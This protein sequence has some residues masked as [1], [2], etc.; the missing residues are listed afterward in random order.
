MS[1]PAA[2]PQ[3]PLLGLQHCSGKL[4][5]WLIVQILCPTM[6]WEYGKTQLGFSEL[7]NGIVISYN[8]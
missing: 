2:E 7:A 5:F 8:H 1:S 3:N 6:A 4:D